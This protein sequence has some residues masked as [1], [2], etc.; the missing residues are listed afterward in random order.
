MTLKLSLDEFGGVRNWVDAFG[1]LLRSDSAS[2]DMVTPAFRLIRYDDAWRPLGAAGDSALAMDI[3]D[4][5]STVKFTG[6]YGGERSFAYGATPNRPFP[7]FW[8]AAFDAWPY[9]GDIHPHAPMRFAGRLH[10]QRVRAL[11]A[12]GVRFTVTVRDLRTAQT[13]GTQ[14]VI[15]MP[16]GVEIPLPQAGRCYGTQEMYET[17]APITHDLADPAMRRSWYYLEAELFGMRSPRP[18]ADSLER[19]IFD[20]DAVHVGTP[21][22]AFSED[23]RRWWAI[24]S[25]ADYGAAAI[26][27]RQRLRYFSTLYLRPGGEASWSWVIWRS[28]SQEPSRLVLQC[29]REGGFFDQLNPRSFRPMGAPA[30][31]IAFANISRLPYQMDQIRALKPGLVLLNYHYDHIS[32]TSN[33]YGEWTTYEGFRYSEAKLKELIAQLRAAG[34]PAIGAYGTQVEQP[35][36]QRVLRQDDIVLDAWGRRYH[37]WEPGNWVVDGGNRDCGE[38]LA[39]AEAEFCQHY[40]LDAVFV[41]RLDHMGINANPARIGKPGDQRLECIPSIRLGMIELNKQRMAWMRKLNPHLRVGLN[42]TTGWSGVRY[43]D[44]NQLEGGNRGNR[45]IPWLQQPAGVVD[46][47]HTTP[48]FGPPSGPDLF[49]VIGDDKHRDEFDAIMRRFMGESL[50]GGIEASPYGDEWFVDPKSMF[51]TGNNNKHAPDEQKLAKI[52]AVR[53]SGGAEWWRMWQAIRPALQA[54]L[55]LATPPARVTDRPDQGSLPAGCFLHARA[56][57][58]GGVFVAVRNTGDQAVCVSFRFHGF[59]MEGEIPPDAVRV[60]W[61]AAPAAG[62]GEGEGEVASVTHSLCRA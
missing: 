58:A 33:L 46:K 24:A 49:Q 20:A 13:P 60:W 23:S 12:E 40:G 47:R 34:V 7:A 36:T 41:D 17:Y 31:P 44:W 53:W 32:S 48:L 14:G 38:R 59:A 3:E 11:D 2:E 54:S 39:R 15:R 37:A 8:P 57:D 4:G 29:T 55:C 27:G 10:I 28:E 5:E 26:W 16:V 50:F 1:A 25:E 6:V 35:E 52:Q 45:E 9:A 18:E 21:L 19:P 43:S 30:G 51:F 42:N 62:A 61:G 22:A 56:G